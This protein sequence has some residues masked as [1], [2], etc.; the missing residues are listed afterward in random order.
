MAR[1]RSP[2]HPSAPLEE[3][4]DWVKK[5]H[6]AERQH[7]VSREVAVQHMGFTGPSGT[8]DRAMS[9]LIHYG[10]A[11]KYAK[12][13]VYVSDLALR[14]LHPHSLTERREAL[15]EAASRPELFQELNARYAEAPPSSQSLAS[16]L[17]RSNF[18]PAAIGPATKAYI[19][20]CRFLQLEGAYDIGGGQRDED[21]NS[22]LTE[23]EPARMQAHQPSTA[24][25]PAP[26][27]AMATVPTVNEPNINIQGGRT[28]RIDAL[29]DYNGL[30]L[31]KQQIDALKML[32]I[33][34]S[35]GS[36]SATPPLLSAPDDDTSW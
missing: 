28:V 36:V 8:S 1:V 16:Y 10:L 12:G 25:P 20:T 35:V 19:E 27:P 33:K 21:I 17:S 6:H 32:L 29:L 34:P 30:D 23:E 24:S 5:I 9:A 7:P 13:E 11:E 26:P 22:T 15:R 18:S 2:A 4:I 3:A 14:I 31:L